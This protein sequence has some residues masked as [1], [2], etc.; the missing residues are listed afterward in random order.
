[1]T[2]TLNPENIFIYKRF[3]LRGMLTLVN[4][5]IRVFGHILKSKHT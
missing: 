2:H 1:M 4:L 5:V 3:K